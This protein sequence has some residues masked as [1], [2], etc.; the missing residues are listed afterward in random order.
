MGFHSLLKETNI[1]GFSCDVFAYIP[2]LWY[3]IEHSLEC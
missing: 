2:V 1:S 3:L